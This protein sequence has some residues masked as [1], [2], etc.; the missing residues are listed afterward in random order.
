MAQGNQRDPNLEQHPAGNLDDPY[1]RRR[2]LR[3]AVVGTAGVAGAAGVAGVILARNGGNTP[4]V[5]T[6]AFALNITPSNQTAACASFED[7]TLAGTALPCVASNGSPTNPQITPSIYYFIFTAMDLPAGKYTFTAGQRVDT[8]GT[9]KSCPDSA[10]GSLYTDIQANG[11]AT[12]SST[13][14]LT[15]GD[16]G[17]G[18]NVHVDVT[19]DTV[20]CIPNESSNTGSLPGTAYKTLADIPS[21]GFSVTSGQN[22]QIFVKVAWGAGIPASDETVCMQGI[23]TMVNSLATPVPNEEWTATASFNAMGAGHSCPSATPTA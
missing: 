15:Y 10:D 9:N 18:K 5:L 17:N 19:S 13:D 11:T 2:F 14:P 12:D 20:S 22:V 7:S 21:S 8:S 16:G 3:A 4:G 6:K 23:L 1:S